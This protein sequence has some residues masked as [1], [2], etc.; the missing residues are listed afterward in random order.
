M[1]NYDKYGGEVLHEIQM[2][3]DVTINFV[4]FVSDIIGLI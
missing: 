3:Y 2:V 4:I 1:I